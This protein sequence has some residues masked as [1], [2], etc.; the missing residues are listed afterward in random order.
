MSKRT[1][2]LNAA[3]RA[4]DVLDHFELRKRLEQGYTRIDPAFL[5]SKAEIPLHYRKLDRLLGGYL[6]EDGRQAILVN[7]DRPRGLVHMT[8]AHELGH[9]F[10]DHESTADDVVE[11]G[12]GAPLVEQEADQ[13][14]YSLLAPAWLISAAARRKRWTKADLQKPAVVYQLSL[15]LGTS[16]TA[17][18]W[19]LRWAGFLSTEAV[20]SLRGV[21]PKSLKDEVLRGSPL[22][23]P[24]ADVWVLDSSD[25]DCVLEPGWSDR[26][27][28]DLP[29]HSA[30]G[31]LWTVD[32]IQTEGYA[33]KP[34]VQ[35]ARI[36]SPKAPIQ[37]TPIG[38]SGRTLRYWLLVNGTPRKSTGA[39]SPESATEERRRDI[40]MSERVP[41]QEAAPIDELTLRAEYETLDAGLSEHERDRRLALAMDLR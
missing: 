34:F 30:S 27:A 22:Q 20:A 28:I 40:A 23:D 26:F 31:H 12:T 21:K 4:S 29:N 41:F 32:Q 17:M 10:L 14:A 8:C 3:K 13:F 25:R 7:S 5:A 33:L 11:H 38:G 36:Q 39:V 15:R 18:V 35:D 9:F 19:S 24:H 1:S 16:F 6:N 37:A 2:L